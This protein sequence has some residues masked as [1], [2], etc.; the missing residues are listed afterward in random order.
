L[1]AV[2]VKVGKVRRSVF[3]NMC[4]LCFFV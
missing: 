4:G 2:E 3:G 1:I